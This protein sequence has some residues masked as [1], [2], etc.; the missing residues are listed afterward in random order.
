MQVVPIVMLHHLI[1]TFALFGW[2]LDD[3]VALLLYIA[4]PIIVGLHWKTNGNECI[5]DQVTTDICGYKQPFGHI[6][7]SLGIP[8]MVYNVWVVIGMCI[9]A[10]KLYKILRSGPPAFKKGCVSVVCLTRGRT[11]D[12]RA[13]CSSAA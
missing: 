10:Y 5:V 3:P 9:A 8:N 12:K 4:L 6:I 2:I 1:F 11:C 13:N 7:R